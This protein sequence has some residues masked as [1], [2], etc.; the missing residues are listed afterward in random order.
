MDT[1]KVDINN[2]ALGLVLYFMH[3]YFINNQIH[4]LS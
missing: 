2:L 1:Q 3:N 4:L